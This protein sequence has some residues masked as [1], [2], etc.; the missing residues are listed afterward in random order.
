MIAPLTPHVAEELVG[1]ARALSSLTFEP[2]PVADPALLVQDT[3]DVR[4]PGAGQG[5]RRLQVPSDISE[6][7]LTELALA[8]GGGRARSTVSAP[9]R[10]RA[11]AEAGQRRSLAERCRVA[12]RAPCACSGQL[13]D[14]WFVVARCGGRSVKPSHRACRP[15]TSPVGYPQVVGRSIL[16]TGC[17]RSSSVLGRCL[18]C[19][20]ASLPPVP[21]VLPRR[22]RARR[23]GSGA[24]LRRAAGR[25][26]SRAEPGAGRGRLGIDRRGGRGAVVIALGGV[27]LAGAS[28]CG[29]D[30]TWRR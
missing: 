27:V 10:R 7:A 19:G 26:G 4:R 24:V 3:V 22:G 29:R 14:G 15:P 8:F 1:Q 28:C 17:D 12:L 2:F 23:C 6:A 18:G 21:V 30:R 9:D 11:A 13:R 16:S 5:P 20:R 25:A